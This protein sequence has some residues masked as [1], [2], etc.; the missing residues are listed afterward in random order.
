MIIV[1]EFTQLASSPIYLAWQ[2][3]TTNFHLKETKDARTKKFKS[4]VL[5]NFKI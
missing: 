5:G 4:A 2:S 3:K 1:E